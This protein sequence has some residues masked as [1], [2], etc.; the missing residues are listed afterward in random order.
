MLLFLVAVTR[1]IL[2]CDTQ[3]SMLRIKEEAQHLK[4]ALKAALQVAPRVAL[5]R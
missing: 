2:S 3:R 4:Q 5:A 1:I